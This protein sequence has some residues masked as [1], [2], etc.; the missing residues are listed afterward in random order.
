MANNQFFYNTL[1]EAETQ[2]LRTRIDKAEKD[3][4]KIYEICKTF[5]N[6]WRRQMFYLYKEIYNHELQAEVIGR[7]LTDLCSMGYLI[8]T[9]TTEIGDMGAPNKVYRVCDKEPINPMKIP[10][11]ICVEMKFIENDKGLLELDMDAM[12]DEF[13][14]KMGYWDNIFTK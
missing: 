10:K 12:S 3:T 2:E 4:F 5:K 8:D 9:G 1:D 7:A 11:K 14:Q 6:V 13:I